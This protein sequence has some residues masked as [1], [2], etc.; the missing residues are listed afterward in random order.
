VVV[1]TKAN[2][3][4]VVVPSD[5]RT[6]RIISERRYFAWHI[7]EKVLQLHTPVLPDHR[8]YTCADGEPGFGGRLASIKSRITARERMWGIKRVMFDVQE[9]HTA[10]PIK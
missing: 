7:Q 4:H 9:S 8:L 2:N 10:C 6:P 3:V 5:V 1:Q